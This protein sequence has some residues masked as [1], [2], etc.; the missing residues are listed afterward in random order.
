[1]IFL[2]SSHH[3]QNN[4]YYNFRG[5][6]SVSKN[7]KPQ[8]FNPQYGDSDQAVSLREMLREN[9]IKELIAINQYEQ[10]A[11]MTNNREARVLFQ[12]IAK[13]EK[14]HVAKL[15]KMIAHFDEQQR[16]EFRHRLCSEI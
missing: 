9:L 3:K 1:M 11:R 16:K 12:E 10:H 14:H 13:E 6:V 2:I 5:G 15:L 8:L 7:N 4:T